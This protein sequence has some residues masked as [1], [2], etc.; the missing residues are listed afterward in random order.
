MAS[1]SNVIFHRLHD[2]MLAKLEEMHVDSIEHRRLARMSGMNAMDVKVFSDVCL[3]H[4]VMIIVRCPNRNSR[5]FDL[6][7]HAPKPVT[8]KEKSVRS[9]GLVHVGD[10]TYISDYDLM[11]VWKGQ[12]RPYRK[13]FFSAGKN[14]QFSEEAQKIMDALNRHLVRPIQHGA[15][16][17]W[18]EGDQPK[19]TA[20]GDY[21]VLWTDNGNGRFVGSRGMLKTFYRENGLHWP[22]G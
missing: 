19:N 3:A 8:V 17:D 14:G 20:I 16:D 4:H 7:G 2:P 6:S 15:N 18:L 22:Y 21:F 9:T 10:K 12:G 11:S 1:A 5:I 13:I